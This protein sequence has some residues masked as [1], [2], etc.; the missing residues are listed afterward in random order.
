M[1]SKKQKR[2]ALIWCKS[3][4]T[5]GFSLPEVMVSVAIIAITGLGVSQIFVNS[6]QAMNKIGESS[7]CTN[8]LNTVVNRIR[9]LGARLTIGDYLLPAS[10]PGP[11]Q[12][13]WAVNGVGTVGVEG[14]PGGA[15][16]LIADRY[17][18]DANFSISD[19]PVGVN[20]VRLQNAHLIQGIMGGM[21]AISNSNNAIFCAAA[22]GGVYNAAGG[23]LSQLFTPTVSN[24]ALTNLQTTIRIRPFDLATGAIQACQAPLIIAPK[25]NPKAMSNFMPTGFPAPLNVGQID[26]GQIV[27]TAGVCPV[28]TTLVAPAPQGGGMNY[29]STQVLNGIAFGPNVRND[30]GLLVNLTATYV[31]KNGVARGCSGEMRLQ[32]PEDG[33]IPTTP[34]ITVVRNST[35]SNGVGGQIRHSEWLVGP[36]IPHGAGAHANCVARNLNVVQIQVGFIAAG[37][38]PGSVLLCRN[39]SYRLPPP[40]AVGYSSACLAGPSG[41]QYPPTAFFPSQGWTVAPTN[42]LPRP[43]RAIGTNWAPN[44]GGA[45]DVP[46]LNISL[47][48]VDNWTAAGH[49]PIN[50]IQDGNNTWVACD[51]ATVCN[52][53]PAVSVATS[54]PTIKNYLMTFNNLTSGCVIQLDVR[55]VDTAGNLSP[56]ARI[57]HTTTN[58]ANI[59]QFPTCGW[60]CGNGRNGGVGPGAFTCGVCP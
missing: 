9:S 36:S 49:P 30:L 12:V 2:A 53:T 4:S 51:K 7:E 24:K 50:Y 60:W 26:T 58:A 47:N 37:N 38:E 1:N 40:E 33:S 29:C 34:T 16:I 18:A 11:A 55:A 27:L 43:Q 59:V 46:Y 19:E 21:L 8:H 42:G 44:P 32:Y 17:P 52:A 48:G 57:D 23:V 31:D 10:P 15:D 45:F 20:P 22:T 13:R 25:G 35:W 14:D 54:T 41:P 5:R 56:M 28:G 6:H 39:R 3:E